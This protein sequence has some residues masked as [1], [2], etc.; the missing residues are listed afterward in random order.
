MYCWGGN[1]E[2]QLGDGSF[3][4]SAALVAVQGLGAVAAL[5]TGH[6]HSCAITASGVRWCWGDN[7]AGQLG[8][9]TTIDSPIPVH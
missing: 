4:D 9:G 6:H 2:G 5:A 7:S 8:D 3:V 1:D